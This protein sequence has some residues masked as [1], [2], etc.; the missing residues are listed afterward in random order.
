M[1]PR[2]SSKATKKKWTTGYAYKATYQ[3]QMEFLK[4]FMK[5]RNTVG[6]PT[7]PLGESQLEE[8]DITLHDA[9]IY[10]PI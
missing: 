4:P 2:S 6:Y 3:K 5:N 9:L 10:G 7:S 8:D 1:S